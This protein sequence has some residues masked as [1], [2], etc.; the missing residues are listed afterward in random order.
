MFGIQMRFNWNMCLII[1]FIIGQHWFREW[2]V[3]SK[4]QAIAW[5]NVDQDVGRHLARLGHNESYIYW[6]LSNVPV[7]EKLFSVSSTMSDSYICRANMSW[8]YTSGSNYS[9]NW[10]FLAII[11]LMKLHWKVQLSTGGH[12]CEPSIDV[13]ALNGNRACWRYFLV[14]CCNVV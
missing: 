2:Y 10:S 4:E 7:C 5:T 11:L 9:F 6:Y 8:I 12:C 1:L 14:L 13:R 3:T